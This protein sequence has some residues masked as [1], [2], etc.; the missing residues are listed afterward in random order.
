MIIIMEKV[1]HV[2]T[3]IERYIFCVCHSGMNFLSHKYIHI[4]Y[5]KTII[6]FHV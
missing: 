6:S 4:L 5:Q 2:I 3:S 1:V